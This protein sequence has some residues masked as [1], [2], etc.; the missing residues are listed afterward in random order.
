M[1]NGKNEKK[2]CVR[3]WPIEGC[4]FRFSETR[5]VLRNGHHRTELVVNGFGNR[6]FTHGNSPLDCVRKFKKF[7]LEA[8]KTFEV[9]G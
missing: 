1:T 7:C 8:V 9:E 5:N 3:S 2:V 6:V 4:V